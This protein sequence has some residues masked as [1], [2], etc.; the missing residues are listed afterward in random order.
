M[1]LSISALV[2]ACPT[3]MAALRA[4]VSASRCWM[5]ASMPVLLSFMLS[6]MLVSSTAGCMSS[7]PAGIPLTAKLPPP[8]GD[9]SN[10]SAFSSSVASSSRSASAME[11][12]TT[13][14]NRSPCVETGCP[15][16]WPRYLSYNILMWA[17]CW[18]TIIIPDLTGVRMYCPCNCM[19]SELISIVSSSCEA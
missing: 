7:K 19:C 8:K 1:R 3:T 9:S 6:T 17:L 11:N 16:I 14:G 15:S 5:S 10:P 4:M 18:F 12:C 13:S 2:S